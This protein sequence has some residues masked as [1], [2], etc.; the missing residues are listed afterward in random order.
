V[1]QQSTAPD[2]FHVIVGTLLA[3]ILVYMVGSLLVGAFRDQA[4]A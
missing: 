2:P 3:A 4:G 1:P